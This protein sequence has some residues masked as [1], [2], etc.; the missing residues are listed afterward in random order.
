[1]KEHNKRK[2]LSRHIGPSRKEINEMLKELKSSSIKNFIEKTVPND[3]YIKKKLNIPNSISEYEYLNHI[4]KISKKNKNYRSYIG[5]GYKNTITPSVI[6]RNILENPGWYT[7]YTPYQSEIS[8]GRLEALLN[9]QTMISDLTGMEISNA[10][11]LD[12]SSSA[13]DAMFMI[14][15]EKIKKKKIDNSYCFYISEEV[16]PQTFFVIKT[17]CFGLGIQLIQDSHENLFRKKYKK[18]FGL[19]LSYPTSLGEIYNYEETI[20]Y[21]KQNNISIIISTDLL[22]LSLLKPPG[23]WGADVVI[24]SSQSFGIPMGYGGPHAAFFSTHEQYKRFLPGRIIGISKDKNNNQAYRMSLQ[25]REQHIRREKATSNICTSQVLPAIMASMYGIYHGKKGLINI[26]NLIHK[27]SKKL[28]SMLLNNINNID[29]VNKFYFDTLRI[30]NHH[31]NGYIQ[32]IAKQKKIN[33]RYINNNYLTITLDETTSQKDINDIFSIFDKYQKKN[34]QYISYKKKNYNKIPNCLIRSSNFLENK[35]FKEYQSET[36]LIRYIKQLER[37]DISLNHSM[38]PLGSCTMKLNSSTE[39]LS[40][41]QK[42]WNNIHPFVPD[43]QAK[44]YQ[45]LIKMLTKY[46]QE[47]TGFSG[48][49]FQPNS[50]AQGEYAGLMVI[51]HYHHSLG[52][53]QRNIALIPSSSHGTNPASATMAGLNIISINTK[54]NGSIDEMDLNTKIKK[55]QKSISVLMI[56]YPS[57]YGVYETNIREIIHVIHKNGGQVYMDGANMNAQ[58]GLM[59]PY[60]LGADICHLNLHKTFS[61]PHGGGGPGMGP[62]C[63]GP[64]LVPFL[65]KNPFY[66]EY[67]KYKNKQILSVSSSPY[68]SSMILTIP[69]AYIRLLGSYGLKKCTEIAILNANYIREK[70]KNYYKILYIGKNKTVAHELVIDCNP[71]KRFNIEVTDIAKRMMDYGFHAPTI[72]FPIDGC[73]MI[74]PT[75]SESKKEID[76]FIDTLINIRK[77]IQ[78]IEDG[79]YSTKDNVLKNAP[80]SVETLTHDNW[81]YPYSRKK[82]S[83]PLTWIKKRKFWIPID[84]VND[85]YGDRNFICRC[86]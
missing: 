60:D 8:Q 54:K 79:I 23:E 66:N 27:L 57:T 9:F 39:L 25:T 7:P 85:V 55:Y 12:E 77:E 32:N 46:F 1:M 14:Y 10:S 68:G 24:G 67:K 63:V 80:H 82:A 18:I 34:K 6:Q 73:M 81:I 28:E 45:F 51:K 5:L 29:Q 2:F 74:E 86:I 20:E 64:H 36:N 48:V 17:R 15:Q 16:L 35:I 11:M 56:T 41:S 42:Q 37:K 70:I 22:A 33:F 21:A 19:M 3:I 78:E 75:E 62:I 13:A 40:I 30:K 84:R 58:I 83:Y 65:P 52:Q 50:G 49:S 76:F 61:I 71:F 59:N 31:S 47:I 43:E 44:G 53:N 69:Y 26:A 4:N 72:S 38:I